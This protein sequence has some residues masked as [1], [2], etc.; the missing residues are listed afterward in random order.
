MGFITAAIVV[1]A[2]AVVG[3]GL[4]AANQEKQAAK[5]YK[6]EAERKAGEIAE[7]E[8]NRQY[9]PNPYENIRDLSGIA[10]NVSGLAQ[11]A[12]GNI[13][14]VSGM[15][16][17]L[18]G[19][20]TNVSGMATNLSG[21]ATNLSGM[22][23]NPFANLGVATQAAEMQ[24][25]EADLSLANTLDTIRATGSGAGGA[26]ALAQAALQS[27]KGVSASIEQ[28]ESNNEKL[29]AEGIT[30]MQEQKMAE[31]QRLQNIGMSEAQRIQNVGMSEAQRVQNIGISENQRIQNIGMSEAQRI[32]TAQF[33]EAQRLQGINISEAQRLQGVEFSE[34]QRMQAAET[35]GIKFQYGEQESRDIARLNRLSGQE[36]QQ[37]A[38]QA[39]AKQGQSAAYGGIASGIG[40]IAGGVAAGSDRKLKKNIN[41]IGISPSG[42]NIYSFEY[43][44]KKFGDGLWQGVMSDEI[45]SD[46]IIRHEDGY[47]MVNYS[48]LDVEFKQ[49]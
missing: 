4:I 41:K 33:S 49:L 9:I 23:N 48:L 14:N 24:A 20:A 3:G 18:S 15:A 1:G 32:Q 2:A 27:K 39:S 5:G 13:Q 34:A 16:T 28:Q 45:T 40:S 29:K 36:A 11:D 47:D 25:E 21:M 35:E 19:M 31:A 46:A 17:N 7:I 12:S 30:R 22:I 6:N 10:Q 42:I 26:T 38:N 37:R 8:A 44:D 43:K